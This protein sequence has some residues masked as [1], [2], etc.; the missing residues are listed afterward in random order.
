MY[1]YCGNYVC[2]RFRPN[3]LEQEYKRK[4]KRSDTDTPQ[5][6]CISDRT[7]KMGTEF[8]EDLVSYKSFRF[9]STFV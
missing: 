4:G 3:F 5:D 9:S 6:V 2:I 7:V 8:R 1:P